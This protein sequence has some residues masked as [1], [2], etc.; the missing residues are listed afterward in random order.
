MDEMAKEGGFRPDDVSPEKA[1]A[2]R[3]FPI[4]LICGTR[5]HRIPGRHADRIYRAARGPKELGKCPGRPK[6]DRILPVL[7]SRVSISALFWLIRPRK[8]DLVFRRTALRPQWGRTKNS[9]HDRQCREYPDGANRTCFCLHV[10][11]VLIIASQF[12]RQI[13]CAV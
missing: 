12:S 9:S 2:A 5:D 10:Q 8:I 6:L 11:V 7:R 13:H 4:F 1:V 3:P